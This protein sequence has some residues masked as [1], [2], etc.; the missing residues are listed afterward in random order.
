MAEMYDDLML[1]NEVV[2]YSS[3]IVLKRTGAGG[4]FSKRCQLLLTSYPRLLCV[5]EST[6]TLKVLCEVILRPVP[7]N[8]TDDQR[9]RGVYAAL[10]RTTSQRS[11][12]TRQRRSHSLRSQPSLPAMSFQSM[13]A[14]SRG[15]SRMGAN[16]TASDAY[17][18]YPSSGTPSSVASQSETNMPASLGR[19]PSGREDALRSP[20]ANESKY[21]NWLLSVET[22]APRSFIVN[23]VRRPTNAAW[24]S[25]CF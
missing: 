16:R 18:R 17:S 20:L 1:P 9:G 12:T 4:M 22:K 19:S 8:V 5:R 21:D 10:E 15:L 2:S 6:R 24:A 3:P 25:I 7:P 23:T 11:A 13:N 14:L